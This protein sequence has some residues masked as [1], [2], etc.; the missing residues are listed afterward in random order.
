VGGFLLLWPSKLGLGAA[1]TAASFVGLKPEVWMQLEE[2]VEPWKVYLVELDTIV[3]TSL[4]VMSVWFL[5][6]LPYCK[7]CGP[8]MYMV[9]EPMSWS[10]APQCV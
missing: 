10:I 2:V 9:E 8:P 1:G 6:A 5:S 3:S 4:L 7:L